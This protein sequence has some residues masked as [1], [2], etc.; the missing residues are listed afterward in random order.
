MAYITTLRCLVFL[1]LRE[2]NCKDVSPP[3]ETDHWGP[4]T[5]PDPAPGEVQIH[6]DAGTGDDANPGRS[7]AAPLKTIAAA[8]ALSRAIVAEHAA[9]AASPP[10]R[11]I[12]IRGK[13]Y[14]AEPVAL[15]PGDSGLHFRNDRGYPA[16]MTGA[17]PL[18]G[19]RWSRYAPV[20]KPPAP[21]T[22]ASFI[23]NSNNVFGVAHAHSDSV[24]IKF[25]GVRC[26]RRCCHSAQVL[27]LL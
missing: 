2:L 20:P 10:R 6:V 21:P 14:I 4:P 23:N 27:P 13:H 19:L 15:T 16:T 22:P 26:L 7:R 12:V 24:G 8:V 3:T 17:A 9:A 18:T 11:F 25:L 1:Q 5:L